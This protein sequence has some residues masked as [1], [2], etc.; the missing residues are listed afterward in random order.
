[1][2]EVAKLKLRGATFCILDAVGH[3]TGCG[4]FVTDRIALTAGHNVPRGRDV[5]VSNALG[6]TFPLRVFSRLADL[7][8]AVLQVM[9]EADLSQ[10]QSHLPL[11]AG[12]LDLSTMVN[13]SVMLVHGNIA[14]SREHSLASPA[15]SGAAAFA[16][17]TPQRSHV[18]TSNGYIVDFSET[19]IFCDLR[20]FKGDSGASLLLHGSQLVGL[21]VSGFN[22][23][24]DSRS[25]DTPSTAAESVRLDL[26]AI[27]S[28]VSTAHG[29]WAPVAPVAA[30][31]SHG[32]RTAARAPSATPSAAQSTSGTRAAAHATAAPAAA[33]QGAQ[34]KAIRRR[35]R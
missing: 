24:P 12:P 30:Q 18:C 17:P 3:P 1:M 7:D 27:R 19:H 5:R 11:P 31:G 28:A 21:H 23:L 16:P 29:A 22:D 8:L 34:G 35:G 13:T 15:P 14:W 4:V 32:L 26:V 10:V 6:H 2:S 25:E 20:T 33:A 9:S